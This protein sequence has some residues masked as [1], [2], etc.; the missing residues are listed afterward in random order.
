[1]KINDVHH[2]AV[3]TIDLDASVAFYTDIMGFEE[4]SRVDMGPCVLVYMRVSK[5][6]CME[7]FD[8]KGSVT[9]GE[10]CDSNAGLRHIAFD[11]DDVLAWNTFLKEQHVPI[12]EEL[13]EMPKIGTRA[14]LIS[15]PNGVVI[16]LCEKL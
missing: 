12:V 1:M 6:L 4:V 10:L 8:L 7:L 14:V 9:E 16:E 3:N 11:V 15:D 2:I 5:D 13:S